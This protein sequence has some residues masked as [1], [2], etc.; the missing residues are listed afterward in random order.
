MKYARLIVVALVVSLAA[1]AEAGQSFQGGLRGTVKDAQGVIPGVTVSL[2][3]QDTGVVRETASNE[4]GEYSF[5]GVVPAGN[6]TD[7]LRSNPTD[8]LYLNPAAFSL[9]PAFTLG[10]APM[11]LPGVRSPLR[12]STDLGINKDLRAGSGPTVT[13][14]LEVINL[15]NAPWYTRM[16]SS[17]VGNATFAQVT[18]QGNYS[19]FAQFTLR[20]RF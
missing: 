8:N 3:N 5:P 2:V 18:T 4:V 17:S 10:N 13:L 14:R 9:A 7:R 6:I 11:V 20:A 15:F 12:T 1:S 19:R 16:A